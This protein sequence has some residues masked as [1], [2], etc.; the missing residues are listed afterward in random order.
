MFKWIDTLLNKVT[1]YRLVLYVL[2]ALLGVAFFFC[3]FDY[4][5]INPF[6]LLFSTVFITMMCW[7]SNEVCAK[8]F[9]APTN[10]ESI[11]I[12][13]LIL[14]LI[15]TPISSPF[16]AA[17]FSIAIW[18][19]IWAM[20]SKY[21]L[22]IGNKHV[23]NPAAFAVALTALALNQSASWW[24]GT[25]LLMPFVLVG[26]LL[27]VKKIRRFDLMFA[28]FGTALVSILGSG[29]ARGVNPMTLITKTVIDTPL[30]F[31][32]F[33][34][35]TE[36]LTSPPTK[37]LRIWYGAFVGF[38]FAPWVHVG[39]LYSTPE[40]ALVL[41]NVFSYFVSPKRK[42]ILNVKE[43]LAIADH[44]SDFL[45]HPDQP[46]AYE[47]GQ[48][49]EW[50]LEHK[51]P[52]SRG[53]RRYFTLASSPTEEDVRLGVKFYPDGSSFKHALSNMVSSDVIVASQL[54]GDFVLPKKHGEK[55]VFIAGGIGIT[56]F[57]SM[58]KYL[59]DR[60]EKRDIVL[61]YSNKSA[62]DIAY[63]D[64]F[65]AAH[66]ELGIKTVYVLTDPKSVP[67]GW[68]GKV[69]FIDA[70]MIAEEAP[71]FAKRTFYLSGPHGMVSAFDAT[72]KKMGVSAS[73]IKRDFFPGFA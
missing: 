15:I 69:G 51:N 50:T 24:V 13:A 30:L 4:L 41:G 44:T 11:Y 55:P 21:I 17:F 28:F 61:L 39:S 63:A 37:K 42:L 47:P 5:P 54:A 43:E 52:D 3:L 6:S 67:S 70:K 18:A 57:R 40:I 38:L 35:L 45:F 56:P 58:I 48:Y 22:A 2:L 62:A 49:M 31:F 36:P 66:H 59:V 10:V 29:L 65:K 32:A 16:D 19:S 73:R 20:A 33:V 71:D 72:L 27:I 26:G 12:T 60:K 7:V 1:M 68:R 64:V 14:A 25:R 8:I 23:F 34:M 9:R 46:L 53:N